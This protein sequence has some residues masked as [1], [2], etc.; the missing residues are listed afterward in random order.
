MTN[1][2][3]YDKVEGALQVS[4]LYVGRINVTTSNGTY[5][6]IGKIYAGNIY[7]RHPDNPNELTTNGAFEILACTPCSYQKA[8]D[9]PCCTNGGRGK[10]CCTNGANNFDCC[11]NGGKGS[12][13]C[14]N[15]AD[16]EGCIID[17]CGY[18]VNFTGGNP[19]ANGFVA[20]TY[21]DGSTIYAGLGDFGKCWGQNPAPA[22][23]MTSSSISG[24]G[25]YCS[26]SGAQPAGENYDPISAQYFSKHSDLKW[27][28]TTGAQA[29]NVVGAVK[30]AN[31]VVGRKWLASR[32]GTYIQV[33][34]VVNGLIY[35]KIPGK[36]E[37]FTS[38][39]DIDVL[40]CV[41]CTNGGS[42]KLKFKF[43]EHPY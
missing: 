39:G 10:F 15:G 4:Y 9:E 6:Q 25:A 11:L 12:H 34:K 38:D 20:G 3:M 14:T 31:F 21:I 30:V 35:Y 36:T 2:S 37:E 26:C 7:Y 24:P 22:R 8:A 43:K 41:P 1:G 28:P 5:Q 23:I 13:C 27:V 16:N 42:G 32:N 40:A 29:A 18:L 19:A 33:G 17:R